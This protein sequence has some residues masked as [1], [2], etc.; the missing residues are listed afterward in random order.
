[1]FRRSGNK[2]QLF[3]SAVLTL[4]ALSACS[5]G[6]TPSGAGG[7]ARDANAIEDVGLDTI[8]ASVDV[9]DVGTRDSDTQDVPDTSPDVRDGGSAGGDSGQG[10]NDGGE[11]LGS[12]DL[13]PNPSDPNNRNLDSDCDGLSDQEEFS[14]IY[15]GGGKTSP[16]NPDTDGD[17]LADGL[18]VGRTQGVTG[19][20]CSPSPFFD[21]DAASSTSPVESDTDN[22]GI[23]DGLED[24]NQNGRVDSGETDPNL[25]DSDGDQLADGLEDKNRNGSVDANETDPTRD[26][27]DGDGISD[28]VE[29]LNRNGTLDAGE[30]NPLVADTDGD[31]LQDG[32]EDANANGARESFETDPLSTDTD[33]DG[34]S[35]AEELNATPPSSPLV[36]DTDGD[37]VTDAIEAG[38]ANP[39]VPSGCTPVVGDADPG[40]TTQVGLADTDG[41]GLSDGTED[42]NQN[43]RVDPGETNPN[44]AD[45]DSDGINDGDE[46]RAGFDPNDPNVP[47][48]GAGEGVN[49]VCSDENLR[50]V[51][52]GVTSTWTLAN[53]TTT[54][55]TP[56]TV[57][58]PGSNVSLAALDDSTTQLTGFVLEMP[59][60]G[61]AGTISAQ[62]SALEARIQAGVGAENLSYVARS[63]PRVITSHDGYSTAVSGLADVTANAAQA[64]AVLRNALVRL[65]TNLPSSAFSGLPTEVGT[66]GT[67]Y[68]YGFQVLLRESSLIVVGVLAEQSR[69]D[70]VTDLSSLRMNDLVNGTALALAGAERDKDCD[71][72]TTGGVAVADFIWMADISG[73]TDDDRGRITQTA[74]LIFDELTQ[75]NVDFRMGVVPHVS[76]SIN[77]P[78]GG[79]L[80]GSGF[81]T[82]R[83]QFVRNLED[84]T[85]SDG[86]EYG[87]Q[88]ASDAVD[89]ALPRSAEGV[90]EDRKI[91]DGATIAVVYI[92]DEFADEVQDSQCFPGRTL[93]CST[94]INDYYENEVDTLCAEPVNQ[95][96]VDSI[97]QPYIDQLRQNDAVAFAQVIV[98]NANPTNCTGYACPGGDLANEPGRG[99][100]EVVNATGGVFYS[101]CNPDP[102]NALR[103]IVDAVTGAASQFQLSGAPISSTIQVAVVRDGTA[104]VVPRNRADGFDY[105]PASNS[106]FFRGTTFRPNQ[107]DAVVTSYRLWTDVAPSCPPG[108][109]L[110]ASLGLCVCDLA[111]CGQNCGPNEVCDS[112]CNCACTPDCNGN[113]GPGQVCNPT[114]CQCEC[115]NDCGG[116]PTGTTC[117][118]STCQCECA[119]CGGA[120]NSGNTTCNPTAC[121]CECPADCGG[122]CSGAFVCNDSLCACECA[123]N[124]SDACSG[125]AQCDQSQGCGCVC[126]DNCG[127]NC[128][129]GTICD[130]TS[131][132]CTCPAG[133]NEACG[134]LRVCDPT[135]GCACVCPT[136][137]GGA[138]SA[139]ER[140][141]ATTCECVPRA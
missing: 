126:P 32:V 136:N 89:A 121:A 123:P 128:G 107:G 78:N 74:G 100:V 131:C 96:C 132:S 82:N 124:C 92:S 114:S 77:G 94:G 69:F 16:S 27:T 73:S 90:V 68:V 85:D 25:R 61:A 13:G 23:S 7:G 6:G 117:N 48:A 134:G 66:P 138:C 70:S 15:P 137:C 115:P 45:S 93:P 17:G 112:D 35:D 52:F 30:L 122:A 76:N 125:F 31:S 127:G 18:E 40:T 84:T 80:R 104:T 97:V 105:D 14:I 86:C 24:R 72:F 113:C 49:A 12:V 38:V 50:V 41:D 26:D 47:G 79:A 130:S 36:A 28:G 60:L 71:P 44:L 39:A 65:V 62:V 1:M 108:Q 54:N 10:P 9:G 5:E 140:C 51:D 4:G 103:S 133:C 109:V 59:L 58:A 111:L 135:A 46:V 57:S 102:G 141:E 37:G 11:D 75:N 20:A 129:S 43:G 91:R 81:T 88:A 106:I 139:N 42:A 101:P 56:I 55:Y 87:L 22:D 19:V 64:A 63:S 98:P 119:D 118:S 95:T 21:A 116:C 53:E 3:L 34:L 110:D 33:C 99:Y 29:D 120:C 2:I 67:S 8:D 83:D